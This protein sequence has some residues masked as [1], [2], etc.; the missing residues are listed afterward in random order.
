VDKM[1][2]KWQPKEK[3]FQGHLHVRDEAKNNL[4][5]LFANDD[6]YK[7]YSLQTELL[8]GSNVGEKFP[9][10]LYCSKVTR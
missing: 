9:N 10:I 1:L 6:V 8:E 4:T 7:Q 3:P 5:W 2:H